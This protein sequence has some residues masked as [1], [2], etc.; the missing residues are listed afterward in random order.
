MKSRPDV[1][2][3]SGPEGQGRKGGRWPRLSLRGGR[4]PA[5]A[6]PCFAVVDPGASVLRVLAVGPGAGGPTVYGWA[7]R[8][9]RAGADADQ[10]V[11]E[12]L[13]EAEAMAEQRSVG[14]PG[15][16]QIIVGLPSSQMRG[17]ASPISQKRSVPAR[18]IDEREL[19]AVLSRAMRLSESKVRARHD[20]EWVLVEAV[21]VALGVDGQGVTDPV[22]FRGAELTASVF[23][24][25]GRREAIEWWTRLAEQLSFSSLTLTVAPLAL[26]SCVSGTH[27][28]ILDVGGAH[29]GVVWW[30][31]GR[32]VAAGSVD[33][34]GRLVT[35]ALERQWRLS[36]EKA[37]TLQRSLAAGQLASEVGEQIAAVI[38]PALGLWREA[39]EGLLAEMHERSGEPLPHRLQI[40]GGGSSLPAVLDAARA[41]FLSQRL[42]F[43]R[44]P[45][46]VRLLPTDVPGIVNRTDR[47]HCAGDVSA[48]AL[49]AW[50][51]RLND[52]VSRPVRVL[53]KL[54]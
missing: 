54:L 4:R 30:R 43:G 37:E 21:P 27:G 22:G 41:L 7:E 47:G 28:I 48:L 39:V 25:A 31:A 14:W 42:T 46:L 29:T 9:V 50:G 16:D 23:A 19:E 40:C 2:A 35:D 5:A 18:E 6:P 24:A 49:A 38:Q 33:V 45:E 8:R 53:Q 1:S 11:E 3:A 44:Y 52:P 26:A 10:A 17:W 15:A 13:A 32:P 20:R 12:A 36:P 51:A 34:G